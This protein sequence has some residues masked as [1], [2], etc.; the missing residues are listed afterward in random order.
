MQLFDTHCHLNDDAFAG[1]TDAVLQRMR[2][3]GVVEACVVGYDLPSSRRAMEIARMHEGLICAV[4]IHPENAGSLQ[5]K[6]ENENE[7]VLQTMREMSTDQT[8]R[9]I[10]EIGLDYHFEDNPP[11]EVQQS[12]CL[13]Q[14]ELAREAGLPVIFHVRDAHMD[15]LNL[16][17]A[18]RELFSGGVMHCF[19]GS[20]EIAKEYLRLGYEI[21]L[22]GPVTFRKAPKLA[23]VAGKVPLDR[24][25]IETDSPYMAPEP[26]R[27][28]RNEPT[29]VRF[30]LRRIAEIRGM[31]EETLAHMTTENAR[32]LFGLS[33]A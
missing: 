16:L 6:N 14:M 20:W 7:T 29:N 22:A 21:S 15:M 3:H 33:K 13:R 11:R 25:L 32:R 27:G 4:G 12:V 26:V 23:D 24:L 18:H 8:V 31:S 1:E 10:G 19:S 5:S 9:A 2:E 30:I 17:K 28:T